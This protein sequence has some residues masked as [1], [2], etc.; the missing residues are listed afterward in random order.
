MHKRYANNSLTA[1]MI[2]YHNHIHMAKK[3][4][5]YPNVDVTIWWSESWN[6]VSCYSIGCCIFWITSYIVFDILPP[7]INRGVHLHKQSLGIDPQYI[8]QCH[9]VCGAEKSVSEGKCER[10]RNKTPAILHHPGVSFKVDRC[11]IPHWVGHSVT[12]RE[13]TVHRRIEV[14][15]VCKWIPK[16]R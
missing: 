15:E 14:N 11:R 8:K 6:F 12:Y 16:R 7:I 1:I 10:W 9:K 3:G 13:T 4:R 5:I 2:R